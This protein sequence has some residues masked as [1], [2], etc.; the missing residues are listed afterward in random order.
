MIVIV[1]N[2]GQR[3]LFQTNST[4]K[5]VDFL[6]SMGKQTLVIS[7]AD[8][9]RQL[10]NDHTLRAKVSHIVLSGSDYHL[11]APQ[12]PPDLLSVTSALLLRCDKPVVVGICF[13]HQLLAT[14]FGGAVVKAGRPR[15][16]LFHTSFCPHHLI[17]HGFGSG[18][19]GPTLAK[20]SYYFANH[21]SVA[22]APPDWKI[23][24]LDDT[25]AVLA[26]HHPTRPIHSFQFHPELTEDGQH[27]LRHL[28]CD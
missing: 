4:K 5:L 23:D 21:D 16:G 6:R 8:D 14:L 25:G 24:Y 18:F 2:T 7:R 20:W 12:L 27:I 13:G 1:N 17:N 11:T 19:T 22:V 3:D 28:L 26:M 15:R 9:L 10:L